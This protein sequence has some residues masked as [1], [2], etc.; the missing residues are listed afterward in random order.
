MQRREFIKL[1]AAAGVFSALPL[2]SRSVFAASRPA[3]PVPDLLT[4]D[5]RNRIT[6]TIQTGKTQF[7]PHQATTWGYNGNLLGPALKLK[8][9]EAVD[10][11][12]RG[13]KRRPYTGM[14]WRC[15]VRSTAVRR[16]SLRLA[17]PARELYPSQR[18]T[19]CWFHPHQHGKPV[20]RWRWGWRDWY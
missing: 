3:L 14:G 8:K 20:V 10:I 7:G 18:A 1:T 15:R 6:L 16:G 9:G 11:H 4:A 13:P 2:W 17:P 5:A 19:T 12:N